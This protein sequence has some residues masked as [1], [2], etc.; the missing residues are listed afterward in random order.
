[1]RAGSALRFIT[2]VNRTFFSG[3]AVECDVEDD[4]GAS[5]ASS[6]APFSGTQP[7]GFL[8]ISDMGAVVRTCPWCDP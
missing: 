4:G 6:F 8:G 3:A 1:V 2:I 5:A 7:F